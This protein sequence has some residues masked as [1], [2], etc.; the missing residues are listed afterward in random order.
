MQELV[1]E[2]FCRIAYLF[3][4]KQEMKRKYNLM[5][6]PSFLARS[7]KIKNGCS[8]SRVTR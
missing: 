2:K 8:V 5:R 4:K 3:I 1:L 6:F 7:I